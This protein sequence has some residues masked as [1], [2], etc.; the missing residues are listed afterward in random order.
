MVAAVGFDLDTR[1]RSACASCCAASPD[2]RCRCPVAR[3]C[4][5]PCRRPVP[6]RCALLCRLWRVLCAVRA[7]A[8][9]S[10]C[11]SV[12]PSSPFAPGQR[13]RRP[14][15][16]NL[17]ADKPTG[18]AHQ[19]ATARPVRCVHRQATRTRS[20]PCVTPS[21]SI[22]IRATARPV[23]CVRV[24]PPCVACGAS[25]PCAVPSAC[26]LKFIPKICKR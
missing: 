7:C 24:S 8:V 25:V 12:A 22:S 13:V 3:P 19:V 10:A 20:Q 4:R 11:P 17:Q 23:R 15:P 1:N 9:P 6:V 16:G 2:C 18:N 5:V 21:A 26:P 14:P